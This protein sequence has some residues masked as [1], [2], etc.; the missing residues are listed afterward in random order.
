M[1][2]DITNQHIGIALAYHRQKS[3][4][5][6]SSTY[7]SSGSHASESSSVDNTENDTDKN[8]AAIATSITPLPPIPYMSDHPYHPSHAFLHHHQPETA[9]MPRCLDR[10]ERTIEVA[11][12]L[13]QLAINRQVKGI[14]V[15]WPGELASA[16][17]GSDDLAS[18]ESTRGAEE[19]GNL[20]FST[21]TAKNNR[22]SIGV[23]NMN[24]GSNGYMRGRI[25]YLLDKCCTRHGHAHTSI[26][27][28]PLLVEGSRPFTLFDTSVSERDWIVCEQPTYS[29]SR[30]KDTIMIKSRDKYGNSITGMDLWGRSPIFG[31]QPPQPQQ[32]KF[33]YSS[34]ETTNSAYMVSSRFE[35]GIECGNDGSELKQS[36][37]CNS[38]FDGLREN[39]VSRVQQFRGSLSAMHTLCDF[40]KEH[41]KGRIVLPVWA[42][43]SYSTSSNTRSEAP[44]NDSSLMHGSESKADRSKMQVPQLQCNHSEGAAT[45]AHLPIRKFNHRKK[46]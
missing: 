29:H 30:Q 13:A 31:N 5:P 28:E 27:M 41:L 42:S 12:Q 7:Q 25:L 6:S 36:Q 20:V 8:Y 33:Y 22:R 19:E 39:T 4:P 1:A 18:A 11:D 32:G 38:N 2:I 10:L 37:H 34:M 24:D 14:V 17:G 9:D 46:S 43:T 16:V 35:L 23:K 21:T 15:R 44:Q 26:H 45:L 3:T 40:A